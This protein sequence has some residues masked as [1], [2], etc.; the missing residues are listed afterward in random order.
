MI[1]WTHVRRKH[2]LWYGLLA[3]H[4][5]LVFGGEALLNR[6]ARGQHAMPVTEDLAFHFPLDGTAQNQGPEDF[7]LEQE[8]P[9]VWRDGGLWLDGRVYASAKVE[10]PWSERLSQPNSFSLWVEL[11]REY[12]ETDARP[13]E[14]AAVLQMLVSKNKKHERQLSLSFLFRY[15]L[16]LYFE[17]DQALV[18]VKGIEQKI[19]FRRFHVVLSRS[20]TQQ[21]LYLNG[22]L[23]ASAKSPLGPAVE[24]LD[25]LWLSKASAYPTGEMVLNDFAY[26]N[27]ALNA[28]EAQSIY[29]STLEA[30]Q[31]H[32]N[33]LFEPSSKG[34][35]RP[36]GW[37]WIYWAF[38]YLGTLASLVGWVW[39]VGP[40]WVWLW[41][42]DQP[43]ETPQRH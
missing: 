42:K 6:Y 9:F 36:L 32:S 29:Q 19:N 30:N 24:G 10:G 28:Q 11:P 22:R 38:I 26:W 1:N 18:E 7:S 12:T 3:L 23:A 20:E 16:L 17:R 40:Y 8:F 13:F 43:F 31:R 35:S 37:F 41:L 27:R 4:L 33:P 21:D 25:N 2:W 5:S 39:F 34:A 15:N 14:T